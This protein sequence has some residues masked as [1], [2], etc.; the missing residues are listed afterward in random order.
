MANILMRGQYDQVGAP[1]EAAVPVALGKLGENS[2]KNR[3]GLAEWLVRADNPL[4]AR[5]TVN[6]FW[7]ELFGQG[8]V[9]TPDDFGIMG[10]APT[11][12]E[13]LDWLAVDFREH[14]WDVKRFYRQM[15]TS[16]TYR[17]AALTT[18]EK[19]EKDRDNAL[20][21]RGPR[22]RM[23]AEMVRDYALAASSTL[24]PRM[25]PRHQAVSAGK[26]LGSR[27]PRHRE[28]LPG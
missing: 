9:K 27:R 2:P 19:L 16:S 11:H 21:S 1:V 24:S 20:L 13:L 10:A 26:H 17:Q 18:P 12:P 6:R 5:V 7:Q 25:R 15:L 22:F 3:L 14:G 23:D 4:T 28:I 8:L